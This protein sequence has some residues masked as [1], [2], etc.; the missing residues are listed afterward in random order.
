MSNPEV[1][2]KPGDILADKFRIEQVLGVGGMG[3][4]LA[5]RHIELDDRVAIKFLLPALAKSPEIVA[6][7]LRE[8]KAARKIKS[9]HVAR[10]TD[11]GTDPHSGAPY[12]VME[13]LEG[14]DLAALLEARGALAPDEATEYLLQACEALAEA[15]AAGIVHR[16][17]KP[18]NL[19]LTS[20]ADGSPCVKVLDFG[21]SKMAS[22][23]AGGAMTKTQGLMGSPLYMS[24][25]QLATPKDVDHRSDIWALGVILFELLA[26]RPPFEGE[27]LMQIITQIV[28]GQHTSLAAVRPGVPQEAVAAI[29]RCLQKDR[30]AR[31]ANVGELAVA[32]RPLAPKRARVSVERIS[33]I[34]GGGMSTA[35]PPS[36]EESAK[37]APAAGGTRA[38]AGAPAH[39]SP[40]QSVSVQTFEPQEVL[41]SV[42]GVSGFPWKAVFA[43]AAVVAALAVGGVVVS[44][45]GP[46]AAHDEGRAGNTSPASVGLVASPPPSVSAPPA[47]AS[48]SPPPAPESA[49]AEAGAARPTSAAATAVRTAPAA[50]PAAVA[51]A[52]VAPATPAAQAAPTT[53]ATCNPPF[54]ID[55]QGNKVFKKE[56]L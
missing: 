22:G 27:E 12:M 47:A 16:D 24:P 38:S 40:A 28:H 41:S 11:V 56:C 26:A 37:A 44:R 53:A 23:A 3:V 55:A 5:A 46:S 8:A 43:G 2:F 45:S 1:S 13:L 54:R 52:A 31:F 18:A 51:P 30:A 17:L 14:R 25:E 50:R 35:V 9:E 4:V 32:L 34:V 20:R 19:F 49:S 48:A 42:P 6:R 7:F 10:V 21:I 36:S 39:G 29:D 15:H 33:R